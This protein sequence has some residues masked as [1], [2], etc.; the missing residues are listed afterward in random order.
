M[1]HIERRKYTTLHF[2]SWSKDYSFWPTKFFAWNNEIFVYYQIVTI[3]IIKHYKRG[4]A[5]ACK[6]QIS[7]IFLVSQGTTLVCR[8]L[9][10]WIGGSFSAFFLRKCRTSLW[11]GWTHGNDDI[12]SL[13]FLLNILAL[14]FLRQSRFAEG[15]RLFSRVDM[16]RH[17]ESINRHI[18]K[19]VG[20]YWAA[21]GRGEICHCRHCRRQC[22]IF[23]SGENFSISL[24]FCVFITK[25]VEILWN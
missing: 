24:I 18:V 14:N 9:A 23:A 19:F 5:N 17:N 21:A 20:T 8:Q 11:N 3:D 12:S 22:K 15:A 10:I 16:L 1:S 6:M 2:K 13:L 7:T 4:H 25:T